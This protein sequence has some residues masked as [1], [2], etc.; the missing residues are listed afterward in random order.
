MAHPVGPAGCLR[1]GLKRF[2]IVAAK[3]LEEGSASPA[4]LAGGGCLRPR[5]FCIEATKR[6][7]S[8][9]VLFLSMK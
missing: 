8:K 5:H 9:T 1:P 7:G 6:S 3:R 4:E 2:S